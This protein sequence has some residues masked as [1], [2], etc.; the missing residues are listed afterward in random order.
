MPIRKSLYKNVDGAV[1]LPPLLHNKAPYKISVQ[2]PIQISQVVP[3]RI[4]LIH[5]KSIPRTPLGSRLVS[6]EGF[7]AAPDISPFDYEAHGFSA[8]EVIVTTRLGQ[9][10]D[11]AA[12]IDIFQEGD[13]TVFG[14]WMDL[15]LGERKS[16]E[17]VYTLPVLLEE[18]RTYT[19]ALF[20][21]PGISPIVTVSI[22]GGDGARISWCQDLAYNEHEL[23]YQY[24]STADTTVVCTLKKI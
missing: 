6:A 13:M 11:S 14:G 8:S 10:R 16:I 21:Q 15:A 1:I 12:G 4:L 23:V 2:L 17:I 3:Y 18:S 22:L 24:I 20:S 5:R 19:L 9:V 7:S